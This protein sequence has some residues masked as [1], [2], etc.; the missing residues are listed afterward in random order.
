MRTLNRLLDWVIKACAVAA[1][2]ILAFM[3]VAISLEAKRTSSRTRKMAASDRSR[4]ASAISVA[5]AVCNV[6]SPKPCSLTDSSGSDVMQNPSQRE[7]VRDGECCR[8]A[9][10]HRGHRAGHPAREMGSRQVPGHDS[11]PCSAWQWRRG[12]LVPCASLESPEA[13]LPQELAQGRR[14]LGAA[15]VVDLA[16][17]AQRAGSQFFEP[18]VR[19]MLA[20][21]LTETLV[22]VIQSRL[23]L[24]DA[25]G[26]IH[27]P[28]AL[29]THRSSPASLTAL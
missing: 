12:R 26:P 1:C 15:D 16:R 19:R 24:P 5:T 13:L 7:V 4:G 11:A 3:T 20:F 28:N 8:R 9:Q 17:Q 22:Q 18:P 2:L 23:E 21:E 10:D 27:F 6:I 29:C 25:G 14:R